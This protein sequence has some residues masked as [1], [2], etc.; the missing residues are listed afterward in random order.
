MSVRYRE[1]LNGLN[2]EEVL[3]LPAYIL[4]R[5]NPNDAVFKR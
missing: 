1:L 4:S 5:G 3:D 2:Q